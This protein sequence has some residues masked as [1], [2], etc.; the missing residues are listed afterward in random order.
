MGRRKK[1]VS[2]RGSKRQVWNG[3]K[4]K[5]KSGLTKDD[6]VKNKNGKIVSRKKSALSKARW[7]GSKLSKWV[8]A[9]QKARK[10]LGITGFQVIKKGT[11]YYA[12]ARRIYNR[13]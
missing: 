7:R 9:V 6:Y 12:A 13:M 10:Q 1:R 5:T 8:R 4:Q 11:D 3:S 2:I